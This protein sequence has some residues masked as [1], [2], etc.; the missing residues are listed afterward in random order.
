MQSRIS[1]FAPSMTAGVHWN[2]TNVTILIVVLRFVVI[3]L[4]LLFIKQALDALFVIVIHFG[5]VCVV[6]RQTLN[7]LTPNKFPH[8]LPQ[9]FERLNVY[10]HINIH[11]QWKT[12]Y[13]SPVMSSLYDTQKYHLSQIL[14]QAIFCAGSEKTRREK[15][16]KRGWCNMEQ[17]TIIHSTLDPMTFSLCQFRTDCVPDAVR[18]TL[19]SS[20]S[21]LNK[22][23]NECVSST[24]MWLAVAATVISREGD[25]S[26]CYQFRFDTHLKN[27]LNCFVRNE[28]S[29]SCF[30][31]FR[32][33][34]AHKMPPCQQKRMR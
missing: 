21:C 32:R 25:I 27:I 9:H 20:A 17:P 22:F 33:M 30:Q 28:H 1:S 16:R 15:K 11:T 23:Y 26:S 14:H 2:C 12:E 3:F 5:L 13:W 10:V 18:N 19:G 6:P 8:L 7:T 29:F 24:R 4:C 34:C 31:P